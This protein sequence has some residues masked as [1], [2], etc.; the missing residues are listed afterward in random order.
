[1]FLK[2]RA[3]I[4]KYGFVDPLTVRELDERFQV[5]DGE[6]RLKAAAEE[7]YTELSC[8]VVDVDDDTAKQLTIVLNETRGRADDGRMS[9]LVKDLSQK[10]DRLTLTQV[11]PFSAE[12]LSAML[13]ERQKLDFA[14]LGKPQS[15]GGKKEHFVER[16][17]RMPRD[18]AS[19]LDEAVAKTLEDETLEYDWQA[20]EVWAAERMA[21]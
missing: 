14:A 10:F 9:D 18:V 6:H 4:A 3:S 20:L 11:M 21:S 12:R 16:V 2:E 13:G 1:M 8:I 15:G 19:V 17:F 5:I 7:G